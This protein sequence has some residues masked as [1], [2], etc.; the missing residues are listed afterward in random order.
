M[1]CDGTSLCY[2]I[3]LL[4]LIPG[5]KRRRGTWHP[6]RAAHS[7][8]P[9]PHQGT[10]CAWPPPK[11]DSHSH[12]Q[13]SAASGPI[14]CAAECTQT[15]PNCGPGAYTKLRRAPVES[16][17]SLRVGSTLAPA[18]PAPQHQGLL[19]EKEREG[20]AAHFEIH[21]LLPPWRPH[22]SLRRHIEPSPYSEA[23][24][25]LHYHPKLFSVGIPRPSENR[26]SSQ[27]TGREAHP[28]MA[29]TQAPI[30]VTT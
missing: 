14:I 26:R 1:P 27:A 8:G 28:P 18:L 16:K 19:V 24:R 30:S 12:I 9:T 29:S 22:P 25:V 3:A 10:V 23:W 2:D 20:G 11:R 4:W 6:E 5:G 7:N 13:K 21:G 15:F 17:R